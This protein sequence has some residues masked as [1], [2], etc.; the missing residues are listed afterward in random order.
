[1]FLCDEGP[2]LETFK[3][4]IHIGSARTFL[5]LICIWTL[6]VLYMQQYTTFILHLSISIVLWLL[7][8]YCVLFV[9]A[10]HAFQE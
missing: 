8:Y 7:M 6:P 1:M 2:T 4:I 5:C 10:G 9:A 3:F